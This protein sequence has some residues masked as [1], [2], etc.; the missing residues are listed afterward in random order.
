ME[1]KDLT[2]EIKTD[3]ASYRLPAGQIDID[4]ISEQFG[5]DVSLS[6]IVVT[7]EIAEP[8]ESTVS[9]VE[10][11]AENGGFELIVPAVEFTISCEYNGRTVSVSNFTA[12]VERLIKIPSGVDYNKIT[13]GIVVEPDGTTYHVPT[14]VV[15]IDGVYYAK[16]NSLTNSTYAL[17]WHPIEFGDMEGHWA[18]DA[19]NDMGSRM[20][21]CGVGD[22][23]YDPDRDMTRA[24]FAVIVVRAL[25]LAPGTGESSFPDVGGSN[26]YLPYIETASSYGII[27]GYPDGTFRPNDTITREQATAMLARAMKITGL[28][29]DL[30][31]EDISALLGTYTDSA[32]IS[33][34]AE[35]SIAA[36][37]ETGIVSGRSK[38]MIV[39]KGNVTRAEVAVMVQRLLQGS[40]LI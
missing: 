24:E 36:C 4:S 21:V 20:V 11:A 32:D 31:P 16:I 22:N 29:T 17:V 14:E 35:Y 2:L 37:L 10:S 1:G 13:T 26:L 12:Y 18:K 15:V 34:Y 38:T 28:E 7:V 30:T 8:S 39:P 25:G 27:M 40:G 5:E 19:V 23:N 6:D 9:L 33:A 3:S